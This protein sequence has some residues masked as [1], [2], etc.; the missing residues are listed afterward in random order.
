MIVGPGGASPEVTRVTRSSERQSG[1]L[2]PFFEGATAPEETAQD[3]ADV[4]RSPYRRKFKRFIFGHL[5][6]FFN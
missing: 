6:I 5:R 3:P 4:F 1:R 2:R